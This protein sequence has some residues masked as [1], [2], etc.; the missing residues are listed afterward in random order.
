MLSSNNSS[1][2]NVLA[3]ACLA[4]ELTINN[5][6]SLQPAAAGATC[7]A[8]Y[9]LECAAGRWLFLSKELKGQLQHVEYSH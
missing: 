6:A 7:G 2:L 8:I 3:E 9:T 1:S 4:S 5:A